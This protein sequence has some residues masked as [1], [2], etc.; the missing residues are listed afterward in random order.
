MIYKN[1]RIMIFILIHISESMMFES[2]VQIIER[3]RERV[4]L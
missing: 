3:D 4:R 2:Q 1:V